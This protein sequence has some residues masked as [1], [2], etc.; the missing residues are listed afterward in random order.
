MSTPTAK[1]ATPASPGVVKVKA[2]LPKIRPGEQA[3]RYWVGTT[4][5]CPVQNVTVGGI[6]F[7]RFTG[8]PTFDSSGVPDRKLDMGCEIDLGQDQVELIQKAVSIRVIRR[9]GSQEDPGKRRGIIVLIDGGRHKYRPQSSDEPLARFLYMHR[10]DQMT[11][12]DRGKFPPETMLE[13]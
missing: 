10:T 4:P 9:V 6:S 13:E 8:I 11:A 12:E 3:H 5:E 2:G 7:A 1:R